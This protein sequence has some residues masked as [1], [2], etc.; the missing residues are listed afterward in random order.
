MGFLRC[1]DADGSLTLSWFYGQSHK[2]G[3]SGSHS[4]T[5]DADETAGLCVQNVV[6]L[7]GLSRS[8]H[9]D[10][11]ARIMSNFWQNVCQVL[12]IRARS[13]TS[14]HHQANGQAERS[15]QTRP[16]G[17]NSQS[18]VVN[19]WQWARNGPPARLLVRKQSCINM[20]LWYHLVGLRDAL[21]K[22]EWR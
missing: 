14:Y 1:S 19:R 9:S 2:D 21:Q 20:T 15:N 11:N 17:I 3:S 16:M 13:T 7:H 10:I 4:K 22:A 18:G 12:D 8:L 5:K 6:R